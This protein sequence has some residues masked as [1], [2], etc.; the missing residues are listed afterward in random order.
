MLASRASPGLR[1]FF[2]FGVGPLADIL[3]TKSGYKIELELPGVKKDE[4][5]ID[6]NKGSLSVSALRKASVPEGV[7]RIHS[8]RSFGSLERAFT[9]PETAEITGVEATLEDGVLS[10]VIPRK[11]A[12]TAQVKWK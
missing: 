3:T 12:A 8:E 11:E 4:I 6:L 2:D 10:L 5:K 1:S 7:K 9:L